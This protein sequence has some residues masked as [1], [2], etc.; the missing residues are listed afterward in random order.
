MDFELHPQLAADSTPVCD[1]DVCTVRLLE[2]ARWPWLL[3]IP[4]RTGVRELHDL[5]AADLQVVA[6]EAAA[7][8]RALAD[9][10]HADKINTAALGNVVEQLHVHVVARRRGDTNWPGPVWGCP[11]R[12]P[13]DEATRTWLTERSRAALTAPDAGAP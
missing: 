3:L 9:I 6:R 2:D 7:A 13:Y 10:T 4:R 12:T 11:G 8:G 5:S 1:L